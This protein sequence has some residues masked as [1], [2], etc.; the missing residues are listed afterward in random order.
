[1]GI[2][3]PEVATHVVQVELVRS[4]RAFSPLVARTPPI[5]NLQ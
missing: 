5:S 2:A 3:R 1:V 4:H